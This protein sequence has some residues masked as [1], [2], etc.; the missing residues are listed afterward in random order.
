MVIL[1]T[2]PYSNYKMIGYVDMMQILQDFLKDYRKVTKMNIQ[3]HEEGLW[4]K[5]K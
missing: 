1:K 5:I 4:I 3:E 2:C